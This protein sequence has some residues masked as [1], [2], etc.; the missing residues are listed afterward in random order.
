MKAIILAAGRGTRLLPLT[1]HTPKP[2]IKINGTPI[3]DRIFK[4]LPDEIDEVIIVVGHLKEK[5]ISHIG[6]NFLQHPVQYANQTEVS[7][8]FGALLSAKPLI[9]PGER[10]LIL[11][12][13]DIHDKAE[14]EKYLAYKYAFGLQLM[15]MPGYHSIHLDPQGYIEGFYPQTPAEKING[16]L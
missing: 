15:K 8:T 16:A 9:N 4:A 3:I 5:I 2:L 7:G 10:F 12:G 1:Q 14:L 11:N 6:N 13:D